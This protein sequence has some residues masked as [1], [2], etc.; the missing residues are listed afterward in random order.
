M[1]VMD[2]RAAAEGLSNLAKQYKSVLDAAAVLREIG[3]VESALAALRSQLQSI[4]IERD[5]A[6]AMLE[7]EKRELAATRAGHADLKQQTEKES[8]RL[9]AI[10]A[11]IEAAR[12]RLGLRPE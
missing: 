10:K 2:I 5:D 4:S 3:N 9:G 1:M 8:E 6:A 7:V 12:N 11:A